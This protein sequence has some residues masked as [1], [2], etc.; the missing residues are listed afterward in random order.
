MYFKKIYLL[1]IVAMAITPLWSF[2]VEGIAIFDRSNQ[3]GA[4]V[5][6][7]EGT[8]GGRD[9]PSQLNNRV[10]SIRIA[11]GWKVMVAANPDGSGRSQ[12]YR[13]INRELEIN[14]PV[15]LNNNASFFRVQRLWGMRL[16]DNRNQSGSSERIKEGVYSGTQIPGNL[17]R[18][19][20]SI[21]LL[22]GFMVTLAENR[23][24]TGYSVNYIARTQDLNVNL[25]IRLN[26]RISYI[27]VKPWRD[28]RK[29]GVGRSLKQGGG[30]VALR[31]N[32]DW[33]YNWNSNARSTR[34]YDYVPLH[35]A[36]PS[37]RSIQN[38]QSITT[39]LHLNLFNEPDDKK[40]GGQPHDMTPAQAIPTHKE[41]LKT[42][43]RIGSP[44]PKE[45]GA[46]SWLCQYVSG[47]KRDGLRM[48][49]ITIHWYDWGGW[50]RDQNPRSD[51]AQI[52]ERFKRYLNR[53]HDLY[54]LPIWITEFNAN[55]HRVPSVQKRFLELA[56][57][58][59]D[60]Q[61][62]IERYAYFTCK[63]NCE[64]ENANGGL[65]EI[66]R[67][68]R[69][70]RST[71]SIPEATWRGPSLNNVRRPSCP[72]RGGNNKFT[73]E[74][75]TSGFEI[76]QNPVQTKIEIY[77]LNHDTLLQVFTTSGQSVMKRFGQSLDV[78]NLAP[79]IYFLKIE[80]VTLKFVK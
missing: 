21:R 61:N 53:V 39:A 17:N 30:D 64:F 78:E 67:L 34:G 52:F 59:L 56:L 49:Y 15:V 29:K 80:D 42:G 2:Q 22:R 47:V 28:V 6:L 5:R 70:H 55:K 69:N 77:G 58:W 7:M 38:I 31:M 73:D 43:L 23:N 24:G 66:G 44:A 68:Y 75:N 16:Y 50:F 60:R 40:P 46:F 74:D 41:F 18:R 13:A 14:L 20:S 76:V 9:I 10:S 26:N 71:L 65:S 32:A 48:D 37:D 63:D 3:Q 33:W 8:V 57:P 1:I 25:P 36:P 27:K 35:D 79:G 12:V 54:G 19:I 11:R 51:P 4:S 72:V 45:N 62:F